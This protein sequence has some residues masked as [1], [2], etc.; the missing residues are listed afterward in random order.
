MTLILK[1]R[2][3]IGIL[4]FATGIDGGIYYYVFQIPSP[5]P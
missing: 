4:L 2:K 5:P 3:D 1:R